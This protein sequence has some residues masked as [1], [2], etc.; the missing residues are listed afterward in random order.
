MDPDDSAAKNFL[1]RSF[2]YKRA[3]SSQRVVVEPEI[4]T[5]ATDA[6]AGVQAIRDEGSDILIVCLGPNRAVLSRC[7][8]QYSMILCKRDRQ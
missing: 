6:D 7:E 4:P 2:V 5:V 1:N 3:S 8:A